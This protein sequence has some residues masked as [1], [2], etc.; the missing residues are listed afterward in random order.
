MELQE[1]TIKKIDPATKADF[2]TVQIMN[3]FKNR[4]ET[5]D[6]IMKIYNEK[7]E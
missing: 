5:M 7:K 2:I 6:H 4:A 1:L 3:K